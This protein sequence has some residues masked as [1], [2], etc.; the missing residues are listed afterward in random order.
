MSGEDP[1][2]QAALRCRSHSA[3]SVTAI[4]LLQSLS[5]IVESS[6]DDEISG[7]AH[8]ALRTAAPRIKAKLENLVR[9]SLSRPDPITDAARNCRGK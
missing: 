7:P 4:D 6:G 3:L 1:I 2:T 8:Q 5:E 9:G